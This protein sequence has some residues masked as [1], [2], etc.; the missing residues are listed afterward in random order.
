ML[1]IVLRIRKKG[2]R[3][4]NNTSK[5]LLDEHPLQV[6]P[7]LATL[8]G[9]NE[10]II[11]Q[12]IHYWLCINEKNNNNYI[13]GHYWVYNTYEQWQEQFP[14]WS[15]TT[16]R[17][18]ITKLENKNLLIADNYNNAGFDKTKWYTINYVALDNIYRTS[19]QNEHIDCSDCYIGTT[20]CEQP[21]TIEYPKNT[22][23]TTINNTENIEEI[24]G[25][26]PECDTLY[27]SSIDYL[28]LEKQIIK[29]CNRQGMQN[30]S[31]CIDIIKY[32]YALYKATFNQEH[33]YL[34]T[35]AMDKVIEAIQFGTD[36]VEDAD[37]DMYQEM[38]DQHFKTHY[39]NCDYNICHF[40]T[41]GV[42]NNRFYETCY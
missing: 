19:A 35:S 26:T 18:I 6:M 15:V 11:L 20:Q 5:L 3:L 24:K 2:S 34:S 13:N 8:I 32:Y 7:K 36:I 38:I 1:L 40:M 42:R 39:K 30:Y 37:L 9:L 23:K 16:I 4:M 28:I 33:P 10:A 12:Q 31:L 29:S 25:V 17:R 14:F 41:E 22:T 21:Y 27:S